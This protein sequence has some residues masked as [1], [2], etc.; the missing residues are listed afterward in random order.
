ME[1]EGRKGLEH[2][3][4]KR[5]EHE[6]RKGMQHAT[7]NMH[8]LCISHCIIATAQHTKTY[9]YAPRRAS[10]HHTT[11]HCTAPHHTMQHNKQTA[12]PHTLLVECHPPHT[13]ASPHGPPP[14]APRN[15]PGCHQHGLQAACPGRPHASQPR[16]LCGP[17]RVQLSRAG[18]P[19][20]SCHERGGAGGTAHRHV[21]KNVT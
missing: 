2:E 20:G 19:S 9:N 11:P 18:R 7:C 6:G 17:L 15:P 12:P 3:G 5:L 13:S 21:C 4:R 16:Q 14:L 1:H 10:P 8:R